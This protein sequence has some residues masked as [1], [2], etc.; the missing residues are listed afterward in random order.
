MICLSVNSKLV[1]KLYVLASLIVLINFDNKSYPYMDSLTLGRH[2]KSLTACQITPCLH[3]LGTAG[4]FTWNSRLERRRKTW[5][6]W[7]VAPCLHALGTVGTF[8]W[9]SRLERRR[10]TWCVWQVAP[11]LHTFGTSGNLAHFRGKM[12]LYIT[13]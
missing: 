7:Q 8:T 9:N 11:C 12:N 5:C 2:W 6:V 4:T 13:M 10:K 3:P 1:A